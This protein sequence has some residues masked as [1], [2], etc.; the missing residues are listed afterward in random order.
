MAALKANF[1]AF[2]KDSKGYITRDE[3][4][5]D[6]HL[7]AQFDTLDSDHDGRLSVTEFMS[8]RNVAQFRPKQGVDKGVQ[9]D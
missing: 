8:A 2:D 3:A 6:P 4:A 5:T 1:D 9:R 7:S